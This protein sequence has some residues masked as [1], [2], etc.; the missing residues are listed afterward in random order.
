MPPPIWV[1]QHINGR[2]IPTR[3]HGAIKLTANARALS[4]APRRE[5]AEDGAIPR[6]GAV[7]IR[8][9]EGSRWRGGDG[10]LKLWV[11]NARATSEGWGSGVL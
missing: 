8:T 11:L 1:A 2:D 3:G 5:K 6:A 9:F 4:E 7:S 10:C